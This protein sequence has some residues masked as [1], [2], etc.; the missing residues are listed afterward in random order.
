MMASSRQPLTAALR[1]VRPSTRGQWLLPLEHGFR[2]LRLYDSPCDG[3][4]HLSFES[5]SS[6]SRGWEGFEK[7]ANIKAAPE[8]DLSVP[9][10]PILDIPHLRALPASPSCFSKTPFF[11][12]LVLRFERLL[13]S[14]GNLPTLPPSEVERVA[15]KTSKDYKM[16]TGEIVKASEFGR[17]VMIMKRLHQIHPDLKPMVVVKAIEPFKREVQAFANVPTPITIDRFGRALGV[18]RRKSSV[19]RAWVVEG[20]GEVQINGKVLSDYFGRMHDRS[21]A[22]WAL[23]ATARLDKYNV[24]ALVDGGGT[25]GQAEALTLAI[26]KG[27]VAHEPALKTPLRKAG[28]I[29]RDPRRVERKKTGHV[30]ARKMPAWVKR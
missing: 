27:L 26:A 30:K 5:N 25:T 11:N 3:R 23:H 7:A 22:V 15:W 29:T 13:R 8:I 24:W 16:W 12:D 20:T 6:P 9:T 21:S 10:D 19:A 14:Y 2:A 4:R 17:C 28:C 18:G 1:C